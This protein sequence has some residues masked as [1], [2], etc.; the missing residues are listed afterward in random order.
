MTIPWSNQGIS[1]LI[2]QAGTGFSGLFVYNGA[3]ATGNLIASIAPGAGTDPY[4]NAYPQGIMD[5]SPGGT[6]QA[7]LNGASLTLNKISGIAAPPLIN[8]ADATSLTTDG[9]T[10]RSASIVTPIIGAVVPGTRP[11]CRR[12]G[13]RCQ[14]C[15]PGGQSAGTPPTRCSLKAG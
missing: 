9:T 7:V 8:L 14:R 1:L 11:D 15:R 13:T 10:I 4:G 5:Q 12:P 2:I 6:L 3:P